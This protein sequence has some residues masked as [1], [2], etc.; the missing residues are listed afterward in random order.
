MESAVRELLCDAFFLTGRIKDRHSIL[1]LGSG[2]GILAVPISIVNNNTTVFSIDKS[3]RKIQFQRHIKRI[4]HLDNFTPVHGR[5][6]EIFP[7]GVECLVVK[8]FGSIPAILEK[9]GPH[10]KAGGNALILKGKTEKATQVEGFTLERIISY[11]LPAI[12]KSYKLLTYK[13][14]PS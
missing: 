9:G 4:L 3:L 13:K 7:I 6:E 8:A 2:A 14:V 11:E 5:A 12:S 10:L 1:D